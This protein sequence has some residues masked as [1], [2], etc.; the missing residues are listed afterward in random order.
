MT[1]RM[2]PAL[3]AAAILPALAGDEV[4]LQLVARDGRFYPSTLTAPAGKL[5]RIEISNAGTTPIEFESNSLRKEK[6]LAPG[7]HSVVVIRS[8]SAGRYTFFDDY[9]Q[10]TGQGVLV[11]TP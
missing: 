9:H 3:L 10:A 7:A 1:S 2:L 11:V 6:V 8:P 5:I 4:T